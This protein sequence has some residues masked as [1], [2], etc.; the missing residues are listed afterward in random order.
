MQ[1]LT[2]R[3]SHNAQPSS[4]RTFALAAIVLLSSLVATAGYFLANA[5]REGQEI[6]R[7]VGGPFSRQL[8]YMQACALTD[9]AGAA[10]SNSL[11][12][13]LD[14]CR[15]GH[16]QQAGYF[17][18]DFNIGRSVP[19]G[20]EDLALWKQYD[21][22][23]FP[24]SVDGEVVASESNPFNRIVPFPDFTGFDYDCVP[25]GDTSDFTCKRAPASCTLSARS[26]RCSVTDPHTGATELH[27]IE[28]DPELELLLPQGFIAGPDI[29]KMLKPRFFP[30]L[31]N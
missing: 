17:V 8:L 19:L 9:G 10:S 18:Y 26:I 7:Y 1:K 30:R 15:R 16:S 5:Y 6:R 24:D 14:S 2:E 27:V 21:V 11:E 31:D 22:F 4:I 23:S 20:E 25:I 29:Y 28:R 12:A 3:S 13:Q